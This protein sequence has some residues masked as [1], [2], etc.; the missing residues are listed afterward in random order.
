MA[1]SS[2]PL[3]DPPFPADVQTMVLAEK[4][5]FVA[6]KKEVFAGPLKDASGKEIVPAGQ[7]L[8]PEKIAS[9]NFFL[10]GVEGSIQ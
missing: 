7:S 3:S 4:K 8:S 1:W 2:W 10:E 9:M 6:G 5:D